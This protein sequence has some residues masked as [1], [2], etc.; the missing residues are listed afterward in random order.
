VAARAA[1]KGET[2]Q[3]SPMSATTPPSVTIA[4]SIS[5]N[6]TQSTSGLSSLTQESTRYKKHGATF[7]EFIEGN[8]L[9]W[10]KFGCITYDE[11]RKSGYYD[12]LLKRVNDY[13]RAR[14]NKTKYQLV[15][16][17]DELPLTY[18]SSSHLHTKMIAVNSLLLQIGKDPSGSIVDK[19][20][21]VKEFLVV[22]SAEQICQWT[23][24][25]I[26]NGGAFKKR[27]PIGIIL[28]VILLSEKL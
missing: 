9:D 18:T 21:S 11:M 1:L 25:F 27:P 14:T 4:S 5:T 23:L 22:H 16:S 24:Q 15:L 12:L 10:R 3:S 7:N 2:R 26:H 13:F 17:S 19:S 6:G 8:G 28:Y 20:K